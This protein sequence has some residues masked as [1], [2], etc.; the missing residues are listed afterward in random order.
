MI[1]PIND[2]YRIATDAYAWM[3]QQHRDRKRNGKEVVEWS[4]IQWYGTLQQ[5]VQGLANRM[6]MTSDAKTLTGV[7]GEVE[8][9]TATLCQALQPNFE[10]TPNLTWRQAKEFD[11]KEQVG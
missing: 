7:L 4:A 2:E 5:A 11:K 3:I 9:L 10:V 8:K 6:L 1:L